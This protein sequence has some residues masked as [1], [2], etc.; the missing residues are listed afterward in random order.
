MTS[1]QSQWIQGNNLLSTS[2][3]EFIFS[4]VLVSCCVTLYEMCVSCDYGLRGMFL[5]K[6]L[7]LLF[8]VIILK[9]V[10]SI[11]VR[12]RIFLNLSNKAEGFSRTKVF[13]YVLLHV[14]PLLI[15]SATNLS[16]ELRSMLT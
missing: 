13:C 4:R 2:R 8:L 11:S 5:S 16:S 12:Q 9:G 6:H 3:D 7:L 1:C 14:C 10:I 15:W